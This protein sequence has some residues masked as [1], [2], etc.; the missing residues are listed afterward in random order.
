MQ[1]YR[2]LEEW[3]AEVSL[4][5]PGLSKPQAFVLAL[6]S[7][8]MVL[9]KS[10]GRTAVAGILTPLLGMK[11][12]SVVQR[13]REWCCEANATKG[14]KRQ[15]LEVTACF[16]WLLKWILSLWVGTQLAIA[17][18]ATTLGA[19]FAV[20]A[21]SIVYRGCA[22]PVAW[23]ILR[24]G[25]PHAWN[26]EWVRM[27]KALKVEL[28]TPM[29]VIVLT[30]RG[31]YSRTLFKATTYSGLRTVSLFRRGLYAIL[32]ALLRQDT[33]PFGTL[34]PDP[35][36]ELLHQNESL[37]PPGK[38]SPKSPV[39][40][41]NPTS[42]TPKRRKPR[43]KPQTSL[44]ILEDVRYGR[45]WKTIP[46][47]KGLP[48]SLSNA[49]ARLYRLAVSGR[50][51]VQP[52]T[53]AKEALGLGRPEGC[54]QCPQ[55]LPPGRIAPECGLLDDHLRRPLHL[56]QPAEHALCCTPSPFGGFLQSVF[57]ENG[58]KLLLVCCLKGVYPFGR[59]PQRQA[60]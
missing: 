60:S 13:L 31:L 52:E 54:S 2:P 41:A 17:L 58:H 4:R 50:R 40:P 55:Y 45:R 15:E 8:G 3:A 11:E 32:V 59:H 38:P 56:E 51:P 10:C 21:I 24:A 19:Q 49:R 1:A 36:P 53:G 12:R 42:L 18:E 39:I 9:A 35:W 46:Y 30:D 14:D 23:T 7:F 44:A 25:Q 33:L 28:P 16:P 37:A 57:L 20:L 26:G 34:K 43:C 27:L 48:C 6:Y 29:A 5:L 22:I 47:P